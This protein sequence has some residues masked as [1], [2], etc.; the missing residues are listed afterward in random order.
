M[1]IDSGT[2]GRMNSSVACD[3]ESLNARLLDIFQSCK[4]KVSKCFLTRETFQ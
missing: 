2:G 1:V 4:T 3:E